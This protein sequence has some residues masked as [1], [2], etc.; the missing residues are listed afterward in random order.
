MIWISCLTSRKQVLSCASCVVESSCNLTLDSE[1]RTLFFFCAY[2]N[3]IL[4]L[5]L[6]L[7][8][9]KLQI[10]LSWCFNMVGKSP[11]IVRGYSKGAKTNFILMVLTPTI[12]DV[13]DFCTVCAD[14]WC[15]CSTYRVYWSCMCVTVA[16]WCFFFP[17]P[18]S[19]S[20]PEFYFEFYLI[21]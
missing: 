8:S 20:M 10:L 2:F 5:V 7:R 21:R 3:F 18:C 4:V 12:S 16:T 17:L 14:F 9:V 11:M 15:I 13:C 1:I 19:S 6:T